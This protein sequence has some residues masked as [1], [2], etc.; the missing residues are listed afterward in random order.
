MKTVLFSVLVMA[1]VTVAFAADPV[2]VSTTTDLVAALKQYNGQSQ[3]IQLT[4]GDYV[5]PTEPMQTD[6]NN[7]Y[8]AIFVN[9][10]TLRGLGEKPEDVRLIGNGSIRAVLCTSSPRFENLMITNGNTTAGYIPA[11][12]T[13]V[14]GNSTRGGGVYG[15]G[16]ITNCVI[17]GC[18]GSHGGGVA[19]TTSVYCSHLYGNSGTYGGA[20]FNTSVYGSVLEN[21]TAGSG[22]AGWFNGASYKVFDSQILNNQATAKNDYGGGLNG[23]QSVSNCVFSGN[24][25]AN[26]YV[27]ACAG[28][29]VSNSFMW[30]CIVT[31]NTAKGNGGGI[32]TMTAIRCLIA[33][34]S[35]TAGSGGGSYQSELYD[36]VVSN[37][38]ATGGSGG[39][40]YVN[41][42]SVSNCLVYANHV[43]SSDTQH[44]YGGGIN[45]S[46][47][48][49]RIMDTEVVG[50]YAETD[51]TSVNNR[52][53]LT[54]GVQ[55][56][57]IIGGSIHDNYADS[58][59][60]GC[61]DGKAVGCRI[62]NN[63]SGDT[64]AN[65]HSMTLVGCDIADNFVSYGSAYGCTFH[66]IGGARELT[67][68]PYKV[69]HAYDCN[70]VWNYHVKMTNSLVTSC[71]VETMFLGTEA[72][73]VDAALVNCT[74]VSNSMKAL[75]TAFHDETH[76]LRLVNSA[77]VGNVNLSG[78]P[79]DLVFQTTSVT[80]GGMTMANCL[81]GTT[82]VGNLSD[83]V[84]D[85]APLYQLGVN[86]I[87]TSPRFNRNGEYPYEPKR[88]SPLVGRG[89]RMD[90]MT[91]AYDVRGGIADGKYKRL[92]DSKVDIGCYQCW[93]N[94]VG[95]ILQFR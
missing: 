46:G 54:G 29:T 84:I 37:N 31:N 57:T 58:L 44:G 41:G 17:T 70:K 71:A 23:I 62:Y 12:Q 69:D 64:G 52:L 43:I 11:G 14:A 60:G 21:N 61:R 27:G 38:V 9:K 40:V 48:S 6:V 8:G 10:V 25:N 95:I 76:P 13:K 94:P 86:G 72:G 16:V 1:G 32:G 5:L 42:Q 55:G 80:V 20:V 65:A 79:M 74:I 39:G 88:S 87:A 91:D 73:G 47:A 3:I 77:F 22:G 18:K 83:Y 30:D 19:Q 24:S 28:K 93:L 35:V 82:S 85:D 67:N 45:S 2:T 4:A 59:C 63:D 49:D 36:C 33:G 50:N 90:W 66:D 34:N 56:G 53:G 51:A 7:G 89:V 75:F 68:N 78:N 26:G 92:R 15:A 81:Y